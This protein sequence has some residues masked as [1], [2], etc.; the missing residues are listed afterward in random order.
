MHCSVSNDSGARGSPTRGLETG[1]ANTGGVQ[2]SGM[3][4]TQFVI[5]DRY[6]P[7]GAQHPEPFGFHQT[8]IAP[9]TVCSSHHD[10]NVL[11]RF[12]SNG[13]PNWYAFVSIPQVMVS[14]AYWPSRTSSWKE[15]PS[16]PS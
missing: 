4:D 9:P 10:S 2:S 1:P 8:S 7:H 3:L 5:V 15:M 11:S 6:R 14:F 13:T 12:L 16:L